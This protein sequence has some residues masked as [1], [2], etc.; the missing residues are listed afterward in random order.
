[1]LF[2]LFLLLHGSNSAA[3]EVEP[4][5]AHEAFNEA[6]VA[7]LGKLFTPPRSK[8]AGRERT[9][10]LHIHAS[11]QDDAEATA[12]A[13]STRSNKLRDRLG[14]LRSGL[15]LGHDQVT[16]MALQE[17]G[18]RTEAALWRGELPSGGVLVYRPHS[19]LGS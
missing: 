11:P 4:L 17:W 7:A 3:R 8:S 14:V 6:N 13:D 15:G 5:R 10:P 19:G 18:R 1:M 12:T 16:F 2:V 9:S